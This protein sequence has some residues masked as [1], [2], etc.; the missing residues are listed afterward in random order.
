MEKKKKHELYGETGKCRPIDKNKISR[1]KLQ[2]IHTN[3]RIQRRLLSRI[4]HMFKDLK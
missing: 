3:T 1:N 2:K 4:I